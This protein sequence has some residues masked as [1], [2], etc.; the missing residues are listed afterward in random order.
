MLHE[1][2]LQKTQKI[3]SQISEN[4]LERDWI[5]KLL[6]RKIITSRKNKK[7]NRNNERQTRQENN[8]RNCLIEAENI[9]DNRKRGDNEEKKIEK[10]V[11]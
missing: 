4:M 11:L 2:S 6:I 10:K 8:S 1:Q 3:F 9:G 5:H 7:R